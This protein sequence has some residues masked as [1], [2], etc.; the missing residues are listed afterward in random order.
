MSKLVWA[1]LASEG[2][3]CNMDDRYAGHIEGEIVKKGFFGDW[4]NKFG[5]IAGCVFKISQA[6]GAAP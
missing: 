4:E 3:T 5:S 2:I 6:L 1:K